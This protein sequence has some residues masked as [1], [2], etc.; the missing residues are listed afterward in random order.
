VWLSIMGILLIGAAAFASW[1]YQV[2]LRTGAFPPVVQKVLAKIRG[3]ESKTAGREASPPPSSA[4]PA[5]NPPA[6]NSSST[7]PGEADQSSTSSSNAAP[8]TGTTPATSANGTPAS[9][10]SDAA[11]P[12]PPPSSTG[13][14]GKN[15]PA[16]AVPANPQPAATGTDQTS[17]TSA[18]A[19]P[20]PFKPRKRAEKPSSATRETNVSVEGFTRSDIPDLLRRADIA[21]GKGDYSLAR[22]EYNLVL[23]LDRQNAAAQQGLKRV[24]AA[25]AAH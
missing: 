8:P 7:A 18:N 20:S 2:K 17:A 22:Y 21:T 13:S 6:A 25:E 4:Q 10:G 9:S 24:N 19:E 23:K 16:T 12:Q 14:D 15:Q 11:Q 5:T 1:V 3:E